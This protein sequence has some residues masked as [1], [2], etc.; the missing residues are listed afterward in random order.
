MYG[1]KDRAPEVHGHNDGT[2]EWNGHND[3]NYFF[4]GPPFP[5]ILTPVDR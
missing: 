3:G 2:S 1:H 5:T 4:A